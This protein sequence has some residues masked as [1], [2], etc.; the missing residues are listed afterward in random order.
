VTASG[1]DIRYVSDRSGGSALPRLAARAAA[2]PLWAHAIPAAVLALCFWLASF[3][4][5]KSAN[6]LLF[7]FRR[8][9][10]EA[11]RDIDEAESLVKA[12]KNNEAVSVLYDSF[13][14]YLSDKCGVKVSALTMK[15]A[16]DLIKARFPGAGEPALEEIRELWT[17]LE[18][19]H[20]SPEAAG[21][22]GTSDL[23]K[24]YALLL[25]LLEKE[26]RK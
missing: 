26:L 10:S 16:C 18:L 4:R 11:S 3:N 9:R 6:P 14:D 25:E 17:A 24:K 15:K 2:L 5:F 23:T 20:F 8:A 21:A 12:G 1:A 7:R 13:M 22:E 19:R